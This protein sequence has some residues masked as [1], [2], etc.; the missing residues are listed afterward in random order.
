MVISRQRV[1][2]RDRLIRIGQVVAQGMILTF[3][4]GAFV[5]CLIVT[6][7]SKEARSPENA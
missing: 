5:A 4:V 2:V 3:V 1:W 7:M 6:E